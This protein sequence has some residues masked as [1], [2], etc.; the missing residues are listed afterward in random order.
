M[1]PDDFGDSLF[2]KD[3]KAIDDIICNSIKY[4]INEGYKKKDILLCLSWIIA[5]IAS[6]IQFESPDF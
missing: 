6:D 3:Q 5:E 2:G 4:L 1:Q